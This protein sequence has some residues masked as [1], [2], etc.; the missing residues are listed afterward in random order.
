MTS[1]HQ[2]TQLL[3]LYQLLA[4][5]VVWQR[6]F[7]RGLGHIE[8]DAV[9]YLHAEFITL[10]M[11]IDDCLTDDKWINRPEIIVN[12]LQTEIQRIIQQVSQQVTTQTTQLIQDIEQVMQF[13]LQ[14]DVISDLIWQQNQIEWQKKHVTN[15]Q[16]LDSSWR[17]ARETV[18]HATTGSMA[19]TLIGGAI[20]SIFV[21]IGA[22]PGAILG[23]QLGGL[24]GGSSGAYAAVTQIKQQ[25]N[26]LIKQALS[27]KIYQFI[28]LNER[29]YINNIRQVIKQLRDNLDLE[30]TAQI[31]QQKAMFEQQR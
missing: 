30:L 23:A 1:T 25:K 29:Q 12:T 5:N 14:A 10:Q 17:V 19:G 21:G 18:Y 16:K 2:N 3:E 15:V 20:G 13:K 22:A 28:H 7:Y 24:F 27:K 26:E 8:D 4:D 9:S 31:K 6:Q 11:T